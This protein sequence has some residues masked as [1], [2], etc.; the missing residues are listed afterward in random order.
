[1]FEEE[2]FGL[3]FRA[4][5]TL[6]F[7]RQYGAMGGESPLSYLAIRAYAADHGVVGGDFV[8]FHTLIAA[9]DAEWLEHVASQTP[10]RP[11]A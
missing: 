7:D 9:V 4:F 11:T 6:R 3:Y 1:M 10:K 8:I 2:W 5:E